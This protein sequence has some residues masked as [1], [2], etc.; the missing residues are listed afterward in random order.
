MALRCSRPFASLGLRRW[1]QKAERAL[2]LRSLENLDQSK[3][4]EGAGINPSH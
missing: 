1:F 4:S 2:S 3:E